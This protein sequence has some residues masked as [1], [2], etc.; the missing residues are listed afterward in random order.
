MYKELSHIKKASDLLN[1]QRIHR[2]R[3]SRRI[4]SFSQSLRISN[5]VK[6]SSQYMVFII[7]TS[8]S[9]RLIKASKSL[10][11]LHKSIH[12]IVFLPRRGILFIIATNWFWLCSGLFRIPFC[13][14]G[15]LLMSFTFILLLLLLL[16]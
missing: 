6:R 14:S 1:F 3:S 13:I 2:H 15:S 16:S 7:G 8:Y 5:I 9:Q 10:N 12:H 4:E 11:D